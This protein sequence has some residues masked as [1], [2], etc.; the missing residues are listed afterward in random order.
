MKKLLPLI[1]AVFAF[2]TVAAQS[3]PNGSFDT[4]N[5]TT[6]G[7]PVGYGTSNDQ[8]ITQ[9][10]GFT[11]NVTEVAG[12]TSGYEGVQL[13]TEAVN[14]DTIVAYI[15]NGIDNPLNGKGGI[16]YSQQPTKLELWY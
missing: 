2:G 4:W 11:P 3:I 6:W 12:W 15:D 8:G 1:I 7:N 13:T 16:P 5:T 10:A 9:V 14:G